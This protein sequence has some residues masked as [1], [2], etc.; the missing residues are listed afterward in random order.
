MIRKAVIA[1]AGLGT[2]L[3]PMSKELPKEMLPIYLKEDDNHIVLKPLLQAIFE[4]LYKYGIRDFCFIVGR[5]KRAIEDHFT[6]DWD[7]IRRMESKV[8]GELLGILN[9][10]KMIENSTII[11]VNQPEPK[12]FG[13]AILMARPFVSDEK[14]VACA[15]DTFILSERNNFLKKMVDAHLKYDADSTILIHRVSDPRQYGVAVVEKL[16]D[17]AFKVTRVLEKPQKPPSDIAIIPYYVF[18]SKVM[19]ILGKLEPSVNNEIQLTDAIQAII[20]NGGRVI[21]I[22]LDSDEI[23]IDIGTPETYWEALSISYNRF[24]KKM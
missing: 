16:E 13:H 21:A 1:A 19:E 11:W 17:Y 15:G 2:R 10:Y 9:F 5:G 20:D 7:Y 22:F 3:L 23:K 12:G 24:L 18:N 6:P 4:Q 14:F 8:R